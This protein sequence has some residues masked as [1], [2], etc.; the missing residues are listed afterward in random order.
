MKKYFVITVFLLFPL[1]LFSQII[2][3]NP[4]YFTQ[5]SGEIAIVF[6]A[7]Q[8]NKGLMGYTGDVYAHT[9]LITTESLN[10]S[11]WKHAS[12]WNENLPKYKMT[13]L[14]DNKWKLLISPSINAYY[15]VDSGE[16]VKSLAFVFRNGDG[17]KTGKEA[18]DKDIFVELHEGGLQVNFI[19]P[20]KNGFKEKNSL[21]NLSVASSEP[22]DLTLLLNGNQIYSQNAATNINYNYTLSEADYYE[23]VAKASA[24]NQIVYD[25]VKILVPSAV[26]SQARPQNLKDGINYTAANE[27]SFVLYAPDKKN[28]FLIGDFN[29]WFPSNDFQLKRDGNY[30]WYTLS[31]LNPDYRYGFQYLIDDGALTVSDAYA[32][33]VLDPWN[34]K[35]IDDKIY[36]DLKAYPENKTDG[37]V[38]TFKINRDDYQWEIDDFKMGEHKNMLIYE[39]LLRD[40]TNEKSLEAAIGKLDYLKTLGVSAIEL[41]PVQEFDGNLSWGYNPN[42]FFAPDK[43]YGTPEMYKKFVDECHKRGIAVFLDVVFNHATGLNPFAKLY[44]DDSNNRTAANNPWFNVAAPHPYSV[45]HDFNHEFEGTRRF[46]KGVLQYWISE[47]NI[48]GFR[49]DLSKGF[50]QKSSNESTA[51]RYDQSRIDILS[52]YYQAAKE[53]KTDIMFILEHFCDYDEESVLANKGMFLWRNLNNAFSQAAMGYQAQSDFSG[54]NESLQQWVGYAESHDEERNFYKAKT[55]GLNDI[56]TDSVFRISRVPLNVAFTTLIPGPK[57][58]WQFGEFAYDYSIELNGRTGEKPAAWAWIEKTERK[59]A[60]QNSA[61]IINL[62]KQYPEAFIN[63]NFT[64]KIDQS[65]WDKGRIIELKHKDLNMVVMGNFKSDATVLAQANFGSTGTWYELLTGNTLNVTTEILSIPLQKGELRIY[66]DREIQLPDFGSSAE[67]PNYE[68]T[69]LV[70]PTITTGE[71]N[72]SSQSKIE[73]ALV[74]N[75]QGILMLN[76]RANASKINISHLPDGIYLVKV[77]TD[78]DKTDV[79]KVIK[80]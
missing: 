33:L 38:S 39:L 35:Y 36:P 58:I 56:K 15:G 74:Y 72:I 78:S 45:F 13:F 51:S 3:T 17:T 41:M 61:K 40:F 80:K 12:T 6:D 16:K 60:Y 69:T 2:E 47:Y 18:G 54:L 29:D 79:F 28:V 24:D 19:N 9:G 34:D 64:L 49:L 7:A 71:I 44:W 67:L 77:M 53:M 27:V 42:H 52:D 59:K 4:I 10:G 76:S 31:N 73:R 66:T 75:L 21:L 70:F 8:G 26:E 37:I 32:E 22:A 65:S 63:G 46:F 57:M 20:S 1:F 50:T 11:D 43:A 55:W 68:P 23:F 30:W 25:T 14:G 48:D 5:N 62:R